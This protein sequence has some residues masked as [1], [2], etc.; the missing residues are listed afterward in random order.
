MSVF[1]DLVDLMEVQFERMKVELVEL[2][3]RKP[4]T[5]LKADNAL[6]MGGA[7]A[8][9]IVADS[10]LIATTHIAR[11]D[12]PHGVDAVVIGGVKS[13]TVDASLANRIPEGILP[14]ARYGD[15]ANSAVPVTFSGLTVSFT[16]EVPAMMS[17]YARN[18]P[19][20]SEALKPNSTYYV[21]LRWN[22]SAMSYLFSTEDL[23]ETNSRMYLGR[24]VTN[25]T[26]VTSLSLTR[27]TR[28]DTYRVTTGGL[29]SAIPA[30][31]GLP[32]ADGTRLN[33]SW[34]N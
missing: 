30:T 4:T 34:L 20:Y 25:A 28:I 17:G 27:V 19:I 29:G 2:I 16:A 11:R 32:N 18:V 31:P 7:T 1:S 6:E 21:Y 8:T 26:V 9:Q 23:A 24:V 3:G 5:T 12:N 15:Q 33:S 10:R 13:I 14:I 22:G